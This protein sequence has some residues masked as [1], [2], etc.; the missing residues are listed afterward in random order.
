M[1][2]AVLLTIIAIGAPTGMIAQRYVSWATNGPSPFDEVGIELHR[3]MPG[4]VQDWACGKLYARFG[5]KTLPP[6]GCQD[7]TTPQKWKQPG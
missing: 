1:N 3:Y 2:Q 7:A 6:Y 4:F 5:E